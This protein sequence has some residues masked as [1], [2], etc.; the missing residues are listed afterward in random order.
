M[1][2]IS[3]SNSIYFL[4]DK[5]GFEGKDFCENPFG[6]GERSTFSFFK[7]KSCKKK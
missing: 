2:I 4:T 1:E 3:Q 5:L 7:R 6:K